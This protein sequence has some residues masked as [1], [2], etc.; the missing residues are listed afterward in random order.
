MILWIIHLIANL[1]EDGFLTDS[2]SLGIYSLTE[3][4]IL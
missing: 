3:R 1:A 4:G 2:L